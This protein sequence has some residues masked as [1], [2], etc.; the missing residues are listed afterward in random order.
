VESGDDNVA[1]GS[2]MSAT[3]SRLLLHLLLVATSNRIVVASLKRFLHD[4]G[5][6]DISEYDINPNSVVTVDGSSVTFDIADTWDQRLIPST[7][8]FKWRTFL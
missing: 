7:F 3:V 5:N 1:P 8:R 6:D 2:S 4:Y